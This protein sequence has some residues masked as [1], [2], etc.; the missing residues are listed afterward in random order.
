MAD[1]Y[2]QLASDS[3]GKKVQAYENTIGSNTVVACA[4]VMVSATGATDA[5]VQVQPDSTGKKIQT[6]QNTVSGN[7]VHALAICPVDTSGAPI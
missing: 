2:V 4:V 7:I 6:F 3:S 1:Q 5:F